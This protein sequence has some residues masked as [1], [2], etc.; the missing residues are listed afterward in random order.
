[1]HSAANAL[2]KRTNCD[3]VGVLLSIVVAGAESTCIAVLNN[4]LVAVVVADA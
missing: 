3:A 2:I 4:F 1:M